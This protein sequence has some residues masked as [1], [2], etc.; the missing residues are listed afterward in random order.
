MLT[1][2]AMLRQIATGRTGRSSALPT[3][4][5]D[6]EMVEGSQYLP[7]VTG[8]GPQG[9][10]MGTPVLFDGAQSG[11]GSEG[12]G[13]LPS[14]RKKKIGGKLKLTYTETP[15]QPTAK[16][17]VRDDEELEKQASP[18][19]VTQAPLTSVKSPQNPRKRAPKIALTY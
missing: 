2:T 8:Q 12:S 15:P 11:R 7:V 10:G 18:G 6:D 19:P 9:G 3:L 1:L 13:S 14:F 4:A 17:V 16:P 5:E